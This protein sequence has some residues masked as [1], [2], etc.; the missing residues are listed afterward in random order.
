MRKGFSL[1]EVLVAVVVVALGLLPLLGMYSKQTHVAHV[2]KFHVLARAR[3]RRISESLSA[4]DYGTLKNLAGTV[5]TKVPSV[6]GKELAALPIVLPKQE[7]E[8]RQLFGTKEL[9]PVHKHFLATLKL[10]N[11]GAYWEEVDERGF[12]RLVVY[13]SWRSPS[14]PLNREPHVLRH[15]KFITKKEHSLFVKRQIEQS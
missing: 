14:D 3:A 1:V 12:A 15:V 11:E 10:Y 5:E 2:N 8:M 7:D 13:L 9:A 6:V 4:L